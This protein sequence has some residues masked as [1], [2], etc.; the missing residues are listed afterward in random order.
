M[1]GH[2]KRRLFAAI[3]LPENIKLELRYALDRI[4]ENVL[5]C[6]KVIPE[7]NWHI[8]LAFLG[9]RNEED[10]PK[11]IDAMESVL[12]ETGKDSKNLFI[13]NVT[14]DDHRPPRI[15]WA[16]GKKESSNKLASLQ[17][18]FDREC[19]ARGVERKNN[20]AEF[21]MHISLVRLFKNPPRDAYVQEPIYMEFSARSIDLMESNLKKTGAEYALI[22]KVFFAE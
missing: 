4:E 10:I 8:T 3:P 7:E 6:G 5:S 13:E 22:K 19:A 16:E 15:I 18:L 12:R 9:D 21:I 1:I 2:M 17:Y 20:R 14:F 11:I